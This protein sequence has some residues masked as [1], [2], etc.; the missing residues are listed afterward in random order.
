MTARTVR[1]ECR[2]ARAEDDRRNRT[3]SGRPGP[4]TGT[5]S[6]AGHA[7]MDDT[8]T[9]DAGADDAGIDD[10]GAADAA[11]DRGKDRTALWDR[12]VARDRSPPGLVSRLPDD[13]AAAHSSRRRVSRA[14]DM[15]L[16]ARS[17][18]SVRHPVWRPVMPASGR[19]PTRRTGAFRTSVPRRPAVPVPDGRR[20]PVDLD[21][22]GWHRSGP[23]N[24]GHRPD[25]SSAAA[26][27][28]TAPGGN[29]VPAPEG[30]ARRQAGFRRSRSGEGSCQRRPAGLRSCSRPDPVARQPRPGMRD[31]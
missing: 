10:P 31:R 26:R 29:R 9:D 27:P 8:G 6:R 7:G 14:V 3:R 20:A 11:T 22:S 30:P 2:V 4:G 13:V 25:A 17:V 21:G 24:A 1:T 15:A 16:A 12:A 28:G 18:R 5:G 19:R 23:R